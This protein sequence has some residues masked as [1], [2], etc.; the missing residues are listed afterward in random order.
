MEIQFC[1]FGMFYKKIGIRPKWPFLDTFFKIRLLHGILE[2]VGVRYCT[3]NGEPINSVRLNY[4]RCR[5]PAGRG[6]N[7]GYN[8]MG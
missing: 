5:K 2:L 4:H 6:G 8:T 3:F 1:Q 7:T